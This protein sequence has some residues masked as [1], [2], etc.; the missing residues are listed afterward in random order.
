MDQDLHK[1]LYN[2]FNP[3]NPLEAGDAAYVDCQEVRGADD[4]VIQLGRSIVLSDQLTYQ[5]YTGHRGAGKST[6]LKRLKKYLEEQRLRVIYFAAGDALEEEDIEHTD[7]LLAC[8]RYLL[9]DLK[10]SANANPLINWLK[11]RWKSLQELA[12]TEISFEQTS[13]EA[14]ITQFAKVTS[15][16]KSSPSSRQKIQ[17][18]V[19]KHTPSLIEELNKFIDEARLTLASQYSGIVVIADNLDRIALVFNQ[20]SQRSNHDQIFIDRSEQLKRLKCHMIYTVPISM[21][22]SDRATTL[23]DRFGLI[24]SL[25]MIMTHTRDGQE[26]PPGIDKLKEIVEKRIKV[27]S[28][29]L[30][31]NN[32]FE[33]EE[34]LQKICLMSGGHVR[35]LILLMRTALERTLQ[36]PISDKAAQRAITAMRNTYRKAINENEW[37]ILAKVYLS[38]EKSN[39]YAYDKLLFNRCILEYHDV[40]DDD[41][42]PWY[43]IHPLIFD[44]EEFQRALEK[45]KIA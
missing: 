8:T 43:D 34:I 41:I 1:H 28:N 6:E 3:L 26:Y 16:M 24:Q 7:I 25:P 22:Y 19:E 36:L 13:V 37:Q 2:A 4:I 17:Q 14:G 33:S 10:D 44:I 9:E 11:D 35:N 5:L 39:N 30:N 29:Q 18:E 27:V 15:V 20:V 32:I 21:A 23:E 38:K 12:S 31:L 40:Q 42:K 45:E